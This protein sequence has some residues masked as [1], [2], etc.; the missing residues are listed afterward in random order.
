M[1]CTWKIFNKKQQKCNRIKWL[2]FFRNTCLIRRY[3]Q[4]QREKTFVQMNTFLQVIWR[5]QEL[6]FHHF[7]FIW[8][9]WSVVTSI[10]AIEKT[11]FKQLK[12][13]K[14]IR[15]RCFKRLFFE[16]ILW[17]VKIDFAQQYENFNLLLA[18]SF[19]L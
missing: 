9:D 4:S 7:S 10:V 17:K 13:W 18:K 15:G 2:T 12:C 14:I 11:K 16:G 8:F 6:Q 19:L 1:C 5:K 3:G